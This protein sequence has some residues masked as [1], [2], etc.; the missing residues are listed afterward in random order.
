[1]NDHSLE[2]ERC[3]DVE[4]IKKKCFP[5][6]SRCDRTLG[7]SAHTYLKPSDCRHETNVHTY[8]KPSECMYETNTKSSLQNPNMNG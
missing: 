1:M 2:K 7:K 6:F 4:N 3:K 8:L 5:V